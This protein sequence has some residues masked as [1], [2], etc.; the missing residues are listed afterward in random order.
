MGPESRTGEFDFI[1]L[2]SSVC[3]D[4][5]GSALLCGIGDDCAGY[6][7][8]EGRMQIVTTDAM[9]EGVHFSF[10]YFSLEQLGAKLA[11]INLSDIAAM[12]GEARYALVSLSCPLEFSFQRLLRIYDGLT[13][14]LKKYGV[15][16]VGGNTSKSLSGVSLHVTLI[17]DVE[18]KRA[19]FRSGAR[20]GDSIFVT[21]TLGDASA[22]FE[23]LQNGARQG[24]FANVS[25][26]IEKHLCP[27]PRILE[28]KVLSA[29]S[30]LSSMMDV[31]DGLSSDLTRICEM[32]RVGAVINEELLPLSDE[33]IQY[34][35]TRKRSPSAYALHGGEDYE[36]LFTAPQAQVESLLSLAGK[37]KIDVTRI[38]TISTKP[39]LE[40]M[41]KFGKPRPLKP[42][43][44]DHFLKK[45]S[46]EKE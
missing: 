10:D 2:L 24:S 5:L 46:W 36:L 42:E 37:E 39:K 4:D 32:S 41:N 13:G 30:L 38:G 7:A 26:L 3:K 40:L 14:T 16:I 33:L 11:T 20:P 23:L 9:I 12:G 28:G 35:K 45:S 43:G 44:H 34:A 27:T 15:C 6:S 1:K 8:A 31:S 19:L 17:G 18:Q 22:G 29:S 25:R 21:G